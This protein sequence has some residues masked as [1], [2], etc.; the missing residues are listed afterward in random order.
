MKR[1]FISF[2]ALAALVLT[3]CQKNEAFD[4]GTNLKDGTIKFGVI[5]PKTKAAGLYQG[6]STFLTDAQTFNIVGRFTDGTYYL[7]AN[8]TPVKVTYTLATK[9]WTYP[10]VKFWPDQSLD[11][12]AWKDG[13]NGTS[14]PT[15]STSGDNAICFSGYT[16]ND[17]VSLQNDLLV[18]ADTYTKPNLTEQTVLTF[19]HA[20]TQVVFSAQLYTD[21][22]HPNSSVSVS[23]DEVEIVN[24]ASTGDLT[25]K[26][27]KY[28]AGNL[29]DNNNVDDREKTEGK[30][31]WTNQ[32]TNNS[33]AVTSLNGISVGS[34][35]TSLTNNTSG[36]MLMIPQTFAA[37]NYSSQITGSVTDNA[38]I[39]VKALIR[40]VVTGTELWGDGA[41]NSRDLYIPVSSVSGMYGEWVWGRKI[42]YVIVFGDPNSGSGGGGWGG[43]GNDPVLVPIRLE[44]Q[45]T[46]WDS[47]D[48][49]LQTVNL[50]GTTANIQGLADQFIT[51]INNNP[52]KKYT[53]NFTLISGDASA[54]A[55]NWST[56]TA[57]KFLAGSKITIDFSGAGVTARPIN[58]NDFKPTTAPSGYQWTSNNGVGNIWVYTLNSL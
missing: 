57:T 16:A 51:E 10:G 31:I 11:F 22:L 12:F 19:K 53:A 4:A 42:N 34:T 2:A 55:I 13:A 40:D 25:V 21:A 15:F 43:D 6:T 45:L 44:A 29:G 47:Y 37:W 5:T 26:P 14:T 50:S 41:G 27:F 20:L 24:V 32:T 9:E 17:D 56:A 23:V 1:N 3:S 36:A 54:M 33:F 48:V 49:Y 46:D 30:I 18:T 58:D 39:R 35:L 7:G 38:Y 52:A 8:T 28:P